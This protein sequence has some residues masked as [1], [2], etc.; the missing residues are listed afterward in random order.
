VLG[1]Q[2]IEMAM[3]ALDI[4]VDRRLVDRLMLRCQ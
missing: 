2:E 1:P 4:P 3:A